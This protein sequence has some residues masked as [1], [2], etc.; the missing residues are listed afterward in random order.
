[1]SIAIGGGLAAPNERV[2]CFSFGCF[3]SEPFDVGTAPIA[4][5][6]AGGALRLSLSFD[7]GL[8][9]DSAASPEAVEGGCGAGILGGELNSAAAS[10][11]A[12]A[13]RARASDLVFATDLV[14]AADVTAFAFTVLDTA[15][16]G[17]VDLVLAGA[18]SG[19]FAL[20]SVFLRTVLRCV[21]VP[22]LI[23]TSVEVG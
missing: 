12:A 7:P 21:A 20:S 6:A 8:A 9:A 18:V 22:A 1:M 17:A 16:S 19:G 3:E 5:A 4:G 14:A 2:I 10:L 13:P 11:V 15:A 23:L